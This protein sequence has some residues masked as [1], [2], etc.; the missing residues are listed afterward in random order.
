[1]P[2]SAIVEMVI[3]SKGDTHV[4]FSLPGGPGGFTFR[5]PLDAWREIGSP[6]GGI[7]IRVEDVWNDPKREWK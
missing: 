6:D 1:M 7:R 4:T 3:E 2:A 5:M